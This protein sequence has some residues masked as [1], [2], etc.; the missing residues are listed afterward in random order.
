MRLEPVRLSNP[1]S[2]EQSVMR[3]MLLPGLLGA[4]RDNIDRLND[5]PNL[6]EIGKVYLWDEPAPAPAH[7]AEPGAVLPH[8]PE[9]LGIV[10]SGPLEADNWTGA[11]RATDFYTLKGAVDAA[12]AAVRLRGEYAPLGEAAAHFPFLHPGKA[13]L[14]SVPGAGGVGALGQLRPDV[15][16]AFGIDDLAVYFASLNWTGSL[17][18]ALKTAA[19]EDL[20]AY[21]PA[22]QD[23]AVVVG[24]DV[25][26]AAVVEQAR[27][28]GGKLVRSVRVFDVYEGD[29]VPEDKRSLALRVVMRSPE[30]TLNEKDIAG[31]RAKI[32]KALERE[33]Q[34]TLALSPAAPAPASSAGP[35]AA[36]GHECTS[37]GRAA[38][39]AARPA[40]PNGR[41]SPR[42]SAS[43]R[44]V[45]NAVTPAL[46]GE[47]QRSSA[48]PP[49]PPAPIAMGGGAV[50]ARRRAGVECAGSGLATRSVRSPRRLPMRHPRIRSA[51]PIT[52]VA[53]AIALLFA[54]TAMALTNK[55]TLGKHIYFDADLSEPSGLSCAGCHWP[56]AGWADPD[57]SLPVS[58]GIEPGTY[59]G[60]NAP[61]SGYAATSPTFF[62]CRR[63]CAQ[64]IG[65]QFWDGRAATLA[66]QAKGP[67]LN[68]VEMPNPDKAAVV[69]DVAA[70]V[71]ADLFTQVYGP[72][73]FDDVDAAYDSIADAIAAYERSREVCSYTSVYDQYMAGAATLTSHEKAGLKLFT[74]KAGCSGCHSRGSTAARPSAFT[75][76]KYAN[77]GVPV[78]TD[79]L[80]AAQSCP[81]GATQVLAATS[82]A[83]GLPYVDENMGKMKIPTLR[84]I[85]LTAPYTHNG[86]FATL[87]EMVSF[88][89]TRDVSGLWPAPETAENI[90]TK[91]GDLGLTDAEVDDLVAFLA[92]L[93]DTSLGS[94]VLP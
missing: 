9:G 58:A 48:P 6:F 32:L 69:D 81:T 51:V 35:G 64:Y 7:A 33:F 86:S 37:A 21:P 78:N 34:A 68:P 20:G 67:F 76:H 44:P 62:Y 27:R 11:G 89:N 10:L 66:D 16:A 28:A 14:V 71:Y 1:M 26:A 88:L 41:S 65:G 70:S 57:Q 55:Q 17:R 42:R 46:T 73:A 54:S 39:P 36:T 45:T 15:A 2:V 79:L 94:V 61:T 5:P 29:Q 50:L 53:L 49:Q 91:V 77:L 87:E 31:V 74:G 59:G 3:T 80:D 85:A 13:A 23:L 82:S 40:P 72:D 30:R 63:T 22:A 83:A 56:T 75:T 19:F 12:L 84:N 47:G 60:R 24:R 93:T 43:R 38:L 25:P 90:T 52:V 8:E 18:V 4:V 92:T